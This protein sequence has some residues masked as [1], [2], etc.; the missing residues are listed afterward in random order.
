MR[1][2][3]HHTAVIN[4]ITVHY[5]EQ[6]QGPLLILCHGFP[7]TWYSWHR[8][9][10][11]LAEAGWR[12]VVPDMRGMG[13]TEMP[14]EKEAY[15]CH[16]T[17]GDLAALVTHLGAEQAVFAGLDFGIFAIFDLA[18]LHPEK[19]RAI[20]ALE[21]PHYPDRPHI[22]PLDEA[23]EWA[24]DHFVHIEYFKEPGVAD[25][26]LAA[27]PR[28]FLTRVF[29]ALSGDYHYLDVWKHPPGTTYLDALPQAPPFPWTW[30]TQAEMDA[31]VADYEKSGFTG[32]LN[33]Y[34]AMDIRWHQ[35]APWRGQKTQAPY[36]FIG[37]EE[38]VDL[39]A[40]HGDDPIAEIHDHHADVRRI[41]MLP[42]AGHLIQLERSD[43]VTRL[44]REFLSELA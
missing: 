4:G 3:E 16:Q 39:E 26:D 15:D 14:L 21:N 17:A 6:G 8:Q 42:K 32:G 40:W 13:Q 38:D 29:H 44:M 22:T 5:V 20:I 37:S 25:A 7:H 30:M 43:D 2:L 27:A 35:R 11:P 31:I 23:A 24:K 1:G 36:Y 33:W 12:V 10:G 28:D 9:I 41:E 19:V 18:H 34:R